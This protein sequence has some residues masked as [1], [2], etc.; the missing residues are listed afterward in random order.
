MYRDKYLKY[1]QKYFNL[2][3]LKK[4]QSGGGTLTI[5]KSN[6]EIVDS[7]SMNDDNIMKIQDRRTVQVN[8]YVI[9]PVDSQYYRIAKNSKDTGY[10]YLF[11]L[12]D[13]SSLMSQPDSLMSQSASLMSQPGFSMSQ[14][15]FSM[16]QPGFSMPQP[17]FSMPQPASL[18]LVET[19][20][21]ITIIKESGRDETI[22]INS[23][24]YDK[25]QDLSPFQF[26]TLTINRD[27]YVIVRSEIPRLFLVKNQS[28]LTPTNPGKIDL[29]IIKGEEYQDKQLRDS[30]KQEYPKTIQIRPNS[31]PSIE[32]NIKNDDLQTIRE[33]STSTI[34]VEVVDLYNMYLGKITITGG[35]IDK[36]SNPYLFNNDN[37]YSIYINDSFVL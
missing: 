31:G 27:T 15:G 2:I 24:E 19:P 13:T 30:Y 6:N 8:D 11:Q 21:T 4:Q 5:K 25:L 22:K 17:G 37:T 23:V 20:T 35:Q 7:F 29:R 9:T 1:K 34:K 33:K 36:L 28:T 32:L 16:S 14:P 3:K 10:K 12:E 26:M 18:M